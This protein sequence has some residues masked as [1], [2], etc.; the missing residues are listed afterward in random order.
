MT[1]Y[2]L[3]T[4][5]I[6]FAE[7]YDKWSEEHFEKIVPSA[8]RTWKSAYS[9]CEQLYSMPFKNIRHITLNRLS[10]K[11]LLVIILREE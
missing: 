10:K 8:R 5:T 1:L 6:T 9:Y 4:D 3:H 11:Q 2:D 7:V